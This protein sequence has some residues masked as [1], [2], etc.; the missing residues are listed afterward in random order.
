MGCVGPQLCKKLFAC[1]YL[2][3]RRYFFL[4]RVTLA[5]EFNGKSLQR[6]ILDISKELDSF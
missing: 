3:R 4:V 1:G 5:P 2:K 6:L